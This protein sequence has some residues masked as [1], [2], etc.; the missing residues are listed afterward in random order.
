[1]H[2]ALALV[3]MLALMLPAVASAHVV[4]VPAESDAGGWER[5]TVLVPTEKESPTVRVELRLPTGIEVIAIESKPG[6][7]GRYEPFPIGA[8][9]V[10]WKG[11]R[12]PSGEFLAFEFLAWNPPAARVLKWQATQWYEDGTN[13]RWGGEGAAGH[14]DSSTT[15]KP[16]K[17][18]GAG[19]HRHGRGATGADGSRGLPQ[20]LTR[21]SAPRSPGHPP[22]PEAVSAARPWRA[23]PR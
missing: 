4:V 10:E 5:Y 13:E 8:A 7:T 12:I 23:R 15:L 20:T 16:G 6:W 22:R 9:R 14:H 19:M 3:S 18:S 11:G 21:L 17:G 1:M 2:V